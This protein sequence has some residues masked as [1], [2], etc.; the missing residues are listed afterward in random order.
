MSIAITGASGNLG[1]ATA[2][3][4]L[5]SIADPSNLVLL[6]RDLAKLADLAEQGA[7]VRAADFG[8][9]GTLAAAFAGVTRLLLVSTDVV[10]DRLSGHQAAID[11][12]KAAGVQH[13]IYTSVTRP[14]ADNPAAVVPDHAATEAYLEASGLTWTLLQDN[15]YA[16]LQIDALGA[17]IAAGKLFTNGGDGATAYVDRGDVAAVAAAILLAGGYENAVLDVTGPQALTAGEL[18]ALATELSGTQVEV[19]QLSDAEYIAGLVGAG[20]PE[21]V[22][23]LFASFGAATRGG[24]LESVSSVVA[25]VTGRPAR[26][27]REVLEP[28]L[29]PARA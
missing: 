20:L 8:E 14:T 1:R 9:P 23:G 5:A 25:D 12:A 27:L 16:Q 28:A 7:D 4:A 13:V 29:T 21:P 6:T 10:G 11:A 24:Y 17:A 19:V 3:A 22:A 26:S 15:L 2:E 18:A